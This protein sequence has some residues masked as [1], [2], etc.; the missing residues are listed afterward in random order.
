M[1]AKPN[2]QL[3][4]L[5]FLL[6]MVIT[7]SPLVAHAFMHQLKA[8]DT[9]FPLPAPSASH[10]PYVKSR[11]NNGALIDIQFFNIKPSKTLLASSLISTSDLVGKVIMAKFTYMSGGIK[12]MGCLAMPKAKGLYPSII[13]NRGGNR[14]FG[15]LEEGLDMLQ[16][17]D[18]AGQGFVVIASQYRG[19][20]YSLGED[21]FGGKDV[22]DVLNLIPV[23]SQ[24]NGADVSRLGMFGVSRG[25][26]MTYLALSK[27][28]RFKTAVLI[29]APTDLLA[30]KVN[31]PEM[32]ELFDELITEDPLKQQAELKKRSVIYW[33]DKLPSQTPLLILHGALDW[34]V[35]PTDA[36]RLSTELLKRGLPHRLII[37]EGDDHPL[38]RHS[39]EVRNEIQHWFKDKLK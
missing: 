26:M 11:V 30:M 7:I 14:D 1:L 5:L 18:L 21:E 13:Y 25:G 17:A 34:R 39:I 9:S 6:V 29:G 38:S 35:S 19:G 10:E 23:L 16:L 20:Q 33:V 24:I 12:V 31:R 32:G 8:S 2:K 4:K 3:I 27:S 28:T 36:T 22:Q 15:K 37:Y